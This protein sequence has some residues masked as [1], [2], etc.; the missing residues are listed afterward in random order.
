MPSTPPSA[1]TV[2]LLRRATVWSVATAIGLALAKALAWALTG[3]VAI[4]AS[5]VDSAMDASASLITAFAVRY[6][7]Q[8]AD[9]PGRILFADYCS[10]SSTH[11]LKEWIRTKRKSSF[12]RKQ[13][14]LTAV[15]QELRTEQFRCGVLYNGRFQEGG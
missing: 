13:T 3:S 4:L 15:R 7:L 14:K 10:G 12:F 1:E 5:L 6:S 9:G 2:R 11:E 8:P